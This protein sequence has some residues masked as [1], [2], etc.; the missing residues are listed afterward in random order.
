MLVYW[1]AVDSDT[2]LIHSF[3]FTDA[4]LFTFASSS[5]SL[6]SSTLFIAT[7]CGFSVWKNPVA[8]QH[9]WI[10]GKFLDFFFKVKYH[11]RV[12]P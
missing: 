3:I 5:Y 6:E 12:M 4:I 2:F 9:W 7:S 11:L 1:N 10:N 8:L